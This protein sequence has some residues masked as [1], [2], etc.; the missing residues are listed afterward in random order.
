MTTAEALASARSRRKPMPPHWY[1]VTLYLCP[2][3]GSER[4]AAERVY[5][6]RP[7]GWEITVEQSYDWCNE[8]EA[9]GTL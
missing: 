5:G 9:L 1:K 8:R 4:K 7:K 2:V 3:C 6:A